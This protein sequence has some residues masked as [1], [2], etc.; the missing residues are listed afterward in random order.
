M[1]ER[2]HFNVPL[3]QKVIQRQNDN[4]LF[5][6]KTS[7]WRMS[8]GAKFLHLQQGWWYCTLMER[9]CRCTCHAARICQHDLLPE[10]GNCQSGSLHWIFQRRDLFFSNL[11]C[12]CVMLQIDTIYVWLVWWFMLSLQTPFP[13]VAALFPA[14]AFVFLCILVW[15]AKVGHIACSF[16]IA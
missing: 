15:S 10:V 14:F 5:I 3:P 4:W 9:K 8:K 16:I 12:R 1:N 6:T 7:F 2:K 13:F 11:F